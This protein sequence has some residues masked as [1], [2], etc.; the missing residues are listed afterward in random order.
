MVTNQ[1]SQ[2]QRKKNNNHAL[3]KGAGKCIAPDWLRKRREICQLITSEKKIQE[4]EESTK[5]I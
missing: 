3:P 1:S 5:L 4:V 2:S